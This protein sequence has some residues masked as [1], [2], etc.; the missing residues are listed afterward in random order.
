MAKKLFIVTTEIE[1]VVLA[2]DGDEASQVAADY[3]RDICDEA[4]LY[5]AFSWDARECKRL[6]PNWDVNSLPWG[7]DE[8]GEMP[9]GHYMNLDN[10]DK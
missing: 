4:N 7:D 10:K 2:E 6:P 8:N 3:H 5:S 1:S 9:V